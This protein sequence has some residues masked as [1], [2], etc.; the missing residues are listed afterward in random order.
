LQAF[1]ADNNV[2]DRAATEVNLE[3][4]NASRFTVSRLSGWFPQATYSW[5]LSDPALIGLPTL[6]TS[7]A[8]KLMAVGLSTQHYRVLHSPVLL[9]NVSELQLHK[10]GPSGVVSFVVGPPRIKLDEAYVVQAIEALRQT[11][12]GT[13]DRAF[14]LR[15]AID[16]YW[17]ALHSVQR[18]SRYLNLWAALEKVVNSDSVGRDGK[19]F[20]QEVATLTHIA[21]TTI[22]S[23]RQL[24]NQVKHVP[25]PAR[26][27]T[28]VRLDVTGVQSRDAKQ[29]L[30]L[31]LAA[32][33]GFSLPLP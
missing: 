28:G 31:S 1:M 13:D 25:K 15:E 26:L 17:D 24:N 33:V 10:P 5:T 20:D 32:R 16:N 2:G 4:A 12:L 22:E 19:I 30:D 6:D 21:V 23:L 3:L 14:I 7:D 18:R 29:L 9:H 8:A 27:A 11:W